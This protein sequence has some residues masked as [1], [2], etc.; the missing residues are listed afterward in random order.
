MRKHLRFPWYLNS[1]PTFYNKAV[2]EECG[3]TVDPNDPPTKQDD[4]FAMADTFG[5]N[6]GGKYALTS[7]IPSIQ[8][9]GM[10]GVELMNKDHTEF[11]FNNA[12]GVEFVQHYIDMYNAGAFTD[13]MLNSST[14]GESKS[15][16][17]GT[18]AL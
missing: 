16:N 11:T 10:Y 18:Q 12:K 4:I 17:G 2:L 6:C 3:I 1:G 7:G 8:D 14:S 13:D 15:F 9:F 5:S